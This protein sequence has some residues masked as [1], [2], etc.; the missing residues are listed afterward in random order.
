MIFAILLPT[1]C[2]AAVAAVRRPGGILGLSLSLLRLRATQDRPAG[3]FVDVKVMRGG[4][5]ALGHLRGEPFET[6]Q[7]ADAV[8]AAEV[9]VPALVTAALIGRFEK[10]TRSDLDIKGFP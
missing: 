3:C 7:P 5:K 10:R 6:I 8:P 9:L 4:G 1:G 2:E